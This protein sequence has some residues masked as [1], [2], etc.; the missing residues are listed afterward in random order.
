[1][2]KGLNEMIEHRSDGTLYYLN[3]IWV[4]LKDDVRSLIMDEAHKSKYSV[5]PGADKMAS[6]TTFALPGC[7]GV[8]AAKDFKEK[9]TKLLIDAAGT[10][11][12]CW[13]KTKR[14]R[15]ALSSNVNCKPIRLARKNELK[16][17]GTL[18]M[19]LSDKHQ[20]KFNI[21]KDAKTLMEAI[22][23]RFGGDKKTKKE[24]ILEKMDLLLWDLICPRWS[25]ITAT[26]KDTLQ[27]SVGLPR[28]QEGMVQ[29]SLKGG[30][31]Q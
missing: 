28:I 8:D 5:H 14:S 11:C 18:L 27:G 4:P 10:K 12:C 23:K 26:G 16:A 7:F 30:M 3:R 21:H 22:E 6:A 15:Y 13:Y 31:F 20:L 29:L 19:A 17:R 1:L 2:Q 24:G 25:V 9:Y